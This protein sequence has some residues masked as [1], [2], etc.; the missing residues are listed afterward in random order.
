[1]LLISSM[2]ANIGTFWLNVASDA[3][4]ATACFSIAVVLTVLMSRRRD[5]AYRWIYGLVAGFLV[6]GG[7]VHAIAVVNAWF[8][9]PLL[10]GIMK[11]TAAVAAIVTAIVMLPVLPK[12][13]KLTSPITDSLTSLPNRL[14]FNDRIN[15]AMARMKRENREMLAVMI[16]DLDD[17]KR[18]NE[19]LGNSVGDQL[20]VRAAKR[21]GKVVRASDTVARF[22]GDEFVILL[23]RVDGPLYVK[24]VARRIISELERP[25][26]FGEVS[27]QIGA[28]IGIVISDGAESPDDL[29]ATADEATVRAKEAARGSI[30]LIDR[31]LRAVV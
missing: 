13:T 7:G 15:L 12:L 31:T 14:L 21:L 18:V 10:G 27:V 11:A 5:M 1:M 4:L 16:I 26:P 23:E 24:G 17:F 6:L 29:V 28:S 3:L 30:E 19:S 8:P 22:G 20:L 25:F 2:N 9:D